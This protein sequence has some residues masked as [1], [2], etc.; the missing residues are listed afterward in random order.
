VHSD[1]VQQRV[2]VQAEL[3]PLMHQIRIR[4]RDHDPMALLAFLSSII[5]A[6]DGRHGFEDQSPAALE[7]LI[8]TFIDLDIAETTAALHILAVLAPRETM[9]TLAGNAVERRH[10]PMPGWVTELPATTIT[11]AAGIGFESEPGQ[12]F[13]LEYRWPGG[14]PATY[15]VFDEGLGRGVKDAFPTAEPLSEAATRMQAA[16]PRGLPLT[17]RPLDLATAR[18]TLEESLLNGEDRPIDEENDTWP[19]GRPFLEWLVRLL[20][21][22]G[23]P[24]PSTTA[25]PGF[26]GLH[27]RGPALGP[28]PDDVIEEFLRS[29]EAAAIRFHPDDVHDDAAIQAIVDYAAMLGTQ[30]PYD[31][32]PERVR[33]LLHQYLPSLVLPDPKTAERLQAVLEAFLEFSCRRTNRTPSQRDAL[34]RATRE[35]MPRY[36]GIALS[37]QAQTLRSALIDYDDLTGGLADFDI[38]VIGTDTVDSLAMLN[39][40]PLDSLTDAQATERIVADAASEV[41]GREVLDAL[42]DS[43][44]PDEPF[45]ASQLPEDIRDRVEEVRALVDDFADRS[46]GVE[47]RTACRRYLAVVAAAQ[48]AVFRRAG[49]AETAAAAV[50]WTIGRANN[51]VATGGPSAMTAQDLLAHFGLKGSVSQRAH[52][53]LRG[54]PTASNQEPGVKL[55]TPDLLVSSKRAELIDLRE[56]AATGRMFTWD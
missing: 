25:L 12:N 17:F 10:H 27:L 1:E 3:Q 5:A 50:A 32:A 53:L 24:D 41:G 52:I 31:W 49:R 22:G 43:P 30:D 55:G 48:P 38:N 36:L 23:T 16:A 56:R 14:D 34:L 45:D 13:L 35:A 11:D 42:D 46:F 39:R 18:A 7:D 51:L 26:P 20:P 44:L 54:L 21:S 37:P 9:R 47:F 8:D 29:D 19:S 4:M 6:T 33:E 28:D 15:V 40:R 2:E